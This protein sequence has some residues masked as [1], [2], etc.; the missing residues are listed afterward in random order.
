MKLRISNDKLLIFS[1]FIGVILIGSL[2]LM[3]PGAWAGEKPL[4][5]I[6]ALFT[7]TSAVCV[8]GLTSV[9]TALYTRFG[10]AIILLLI[11]LGGLGLITFTTMLVMLPRRKISLVSRGIVRDF[12][13]DEIDYDPKKVMRNIIVLTASIELAGALI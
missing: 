12:T 2:L 11:Q 8:T 7:S 3:L 1:Y 13:L 10:Q 6:D 5:Y 4:Y 9:D